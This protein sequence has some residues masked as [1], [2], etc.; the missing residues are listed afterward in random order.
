LERLR[1]AV[2]AFAIHRTPRRLTSALLTGETA[3]TDTLD[4]ETQAHIEASVR[5][6]EQRSVDALFIS[7]N[8]YP[9]RLRSLATPP[10]ILFTWGNTDL[11]NTPAVGMCGSRGASEKGIDAARA[12][13]RAVGERGLTVV[14]GYARGVDT[15]THLAALESGGHTMVVLA[16]GILHFRVKRVFRETGFDPERVLVL[17]QF[18]PAQRWN[19]G[20]AMT[21][22]AVIAGL[23]K[24]LV[25]IEAGETGGTLDAGMKALSMGRP[26]MA[27]EFSEGTPAGNSL[28]F[29]H[30][31]IRVDRRSALRSALDHIGEPDRPAS[32][33]RIL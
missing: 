14:S 7:D 16:E 28:L 26:V 5:E 13:G 23:G 21:R 9:E 6:L 30:G 18:A 4:A 15:E 31:A 11:L 25:V 20:A 33:L 29:T 27:L 17:S 22:N 2:A 1:L 24:A 3:T 10:P 12:C 32:Q 19:A 8:R